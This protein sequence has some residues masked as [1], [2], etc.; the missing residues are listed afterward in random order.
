MLEME[1]Y[2]TQGYG[3]V[4]VLE[5]A[6]PVVVDTGLGRNTAWIVA[7]LEEQGVDRTDPISILVTHVHLDHAGGV[8]RLCAAFPQAEVYVHERGARHLSE[9][10]RLVTGTKQAVGH[11]W[12]YY[13]DPVA[14][15]PERITTVG[16]GDHIDAGGHAFAVH[17]APGHAPHQVTFHD[18]DA[19]VMFCADAMGIRIPGT[20]RVIAST[21]P[22]QFDLAL[23]RADVAMIAEEAPATLCYAHHGHRPFEPAVADRYDDILQRFVA[24]TT[25][26]LETQSLEDVIDAVTAD[27]DAEAVWGAEKTRAEASLNVR[28][29]AAMDP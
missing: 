21:P 6:H 25:A 8:G 18:Q 19:D 17:A 4:Y 27:Y 24:E 14:V 3:V 15:P 2:G 20:G 11:M 7:L 22:P 10:D 12:R 9:P 5:A 26:A 1:M 16:D 13:E 28:G 23:A 29:I